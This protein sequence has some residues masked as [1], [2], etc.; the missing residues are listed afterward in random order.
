M[1]T[2]TVLRIAE[3]YVGFRSR[4]LRTNDFGAKAGRNLEIWSG[5]FVHVVLQESG[6]AFGV[7]FSDT[8]ASLNY[9]RLRNLTVKTPKPGDLVF[10]T[11]STD[12]TLAQPHVGIVT[13]TDKWAK[14]GIFKAIEGETAPNAS[15][16]HVHPADGVWKRTRYAVEVLEFVRMQNWKPFRANSNVA[17]DLASLDFTPLARGKHIETVQKALGDLYGNRVRSLRK[18]VW[19][20]PTSHAYSDW[21]R[22]VGVKPTGTPT[23]QDLADLG[24][25][26][27]RWLG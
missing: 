8:V 15:R 18:G 19:D 4:A 13:D 1:N 25:E 27:G 23:A 12:G 16:K 5:S 26:T 3:S 24:V 9:C 11:F 21:Q 6:A 17:Y 22:I 10:Y 20:G 7:H 14:Q 2:E